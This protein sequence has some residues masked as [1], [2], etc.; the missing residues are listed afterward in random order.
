MTKHA[1]SAAGIVFT[2]ISLPP[3]Q[4]ARALRAM[5]GAQTLPQVFVNGRLIGDSEATLHWL[6]G[7]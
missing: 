2:D 4:R 6:A 3:L 1:L 5:T 7:R